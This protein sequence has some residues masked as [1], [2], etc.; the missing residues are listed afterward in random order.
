LQNAAPGPNFTDDDQGLPMRG[1]LFPLLVVAGVA[2]AQAPVSPAEITGRWMLQRLDDQPFSARAEIDLSVPGQV[3]GHAPCNGFSG[4]RRGDWPDVEFGPLRST[5]RACP[6]LAAE[7][8]F[9]MALQAM[10]RAEMREGQLVLTAQ[11][12]REMLF[13]PTPAP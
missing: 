9:L 4:S 7:H 6:E 2:G 1:L 8:A 5:R 10:T 3:S 12:G 13:I 11:D